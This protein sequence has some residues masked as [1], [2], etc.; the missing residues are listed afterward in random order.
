MGVAKLDWTLLR[1]SRPW[2]HF[3]I[4][5]WL[6][7]QIELYKFYGQDISFW[8][9]APGHVPWGLIAFECNLLSVAT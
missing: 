7:V 8:G 2:A 9:V 5:F 6:W 3:Q 4:R 1:F